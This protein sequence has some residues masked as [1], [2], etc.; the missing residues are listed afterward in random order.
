MPMPR[1]AYDYQLLTD[2]LH[3]CRKCQP[4]RTR[5]SRYRAGQ[6][7]NNVRILHGGH[8]ARPLPGCNGR[9][10]NVTYCRRPAE[11]TL[12]RLLTMITDIPH[13]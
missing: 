7:A 13:H 5:R 2:R 8:G 9:R 11:S 12:R 10:A 1:C 3:G 6:V 4:K